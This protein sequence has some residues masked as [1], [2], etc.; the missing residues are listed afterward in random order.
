M[1]DPPLE[2]SLRSLTPSHSSIGHLWK[3]PTGRAQLPALPL[4]GGLSTHSSS[5]AITDENSGTPC[6]PPTQQHA[7]REPA[8]PGPTQCMC[9]SKRSHGASA[10]RSTREAQNLNSSAAPQHRME[11]TTSSD[12]RRESL[13][14]HLLFVLIILRFIRSKKGTS[15]SSPSFSCGD[16]SAA[17]KHEPSLR[18]DSFSQRLKQ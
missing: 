4:P 2:A 7:C 3:L 1:C 10:N 14:Q 5:D 17:I 16:I 9:C 12:S 15:P 6:C 13:L 11:G 8:P 18:K